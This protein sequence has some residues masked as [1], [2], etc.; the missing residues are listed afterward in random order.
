MIIDRLIFNDCII[1]DIAADVSITGGGVWVKDFEF[2]Q[3]RDERNKQLSA[4][5]RVNFYAK[6]SYSQTEAI[7]RIEYQVA[8]HCTQFCE[9]YKAFFEENETIRYPSMLAFHTL[10]RTHFSNIQ[11]SENF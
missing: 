3:I 9:K 4:A 1:F 7:R 10:L 8:K 2:G 11:I 6:K 5:E